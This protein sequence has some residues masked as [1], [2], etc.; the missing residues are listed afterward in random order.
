MLLTTPSDPLYILA[1][2]PATTDTVSVGVLTTS[3]SPL[4]DVTFPAMKVAPSPVASAAASAPWAD[5][6]PKGHDCPGHHHNSKNIA[7]AD[8]STHS[9]LPATLPDPTAANPE[10]A[11]G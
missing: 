10:P 6:A 9:R 7:P 5:S 8:M 4:A 2:A 11:T 3:R 1:S